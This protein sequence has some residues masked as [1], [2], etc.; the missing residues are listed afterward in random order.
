MTAPPV[1]KLRISLKSEAM[2]LVCTLIWGGTFLATDIALAYASP[3]ALISARFGLAA[4]LALALDLRAIVK[5]SRAAMIRGL[6]LGALLYSSFGMQTIGQAYTSVSRSA[7][8]TQL[9]VAFTPVLERVLFRR[10]ARPAT[11]AGVCIVLFGMYLFSGASVGLSWNRGDWIT[12]GC[13]FLFSVYILAIDHLDLPGEHT[14]ILFVQ[15]FVVG[16]LGASSS[17]LMEDV[18]FQPEVALGLALLYLAPLG[19]NVVLALQMRFQP[20]TTPARAAV[21]FTME[22]VFATLMSVLLLQ[23]DVGGLAVPGMVLIIT[24]V[25]VSELGP[26]LQRRGAKAR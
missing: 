23:E 22:P 15:T 20:G 5:M 16:V 14:P 26:G 7:F 12:L 25:L 1:P 24:G 18:R 8:I 10:R 11:L 9:L 13:A 19:V 6:I 21:V 2:L 4:M 17:F 3:M